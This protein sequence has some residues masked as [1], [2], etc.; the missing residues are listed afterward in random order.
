MIVHLGVLV[1]KSLQKAEGMKKPSFFLTC[2]ACNILDK[3]SLYYP[4]F[5]K[6]LIPVKH[7][8]F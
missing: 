2:L 3:I 7:L 5:D 4:T 8:I 1:K 6:I